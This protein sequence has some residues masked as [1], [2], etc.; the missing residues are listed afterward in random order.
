MLWFSSYVIVF[1]FPWKIKEQKIGDF[2][3]WLTLVLVLWFNWVVGQEWTGNHE[4]ALSRLSDFSWPARSPDLSMCGYFLWGYLQSKVY[5]R[6][7]HTFGDLKLVFQSST[8]VQH[9]GKIKIIKIKY[10]M[11]VF[12]MGK[13]I[14]QILYLNITP[15]QKGNKLQVDLSRDW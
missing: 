4:N 7:P 5:I 12:K 14:N 11:Q 2:T 10:I 13:Y 1:E 15:P 6:R 8:F 9:W 3:Y